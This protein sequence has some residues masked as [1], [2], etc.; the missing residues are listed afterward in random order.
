MK[1]A[2]L[3]RTCLH[4][5]CLCRGCKAMRGDEC[6]RLCRALLRACLPVASVMAS[7]K[8]EGPRP[9]EN[10]EK[11]QSFFPRSL[12]AMDSTTTYCFF[13]SFTQTKENREHKSQSISA[14][15]QASRWQRPLSH[16][17]RN[18]MCL[19]LSLSVDHAAVCV[20]DR[21]KNPR[22]HLREVHVKSRT[23]TSRRFRGARV[24]HASMSSFYYRLRIL[25]GWH[26][27]ENVK[28]HAS[29][30]H[31]WPAARGSEK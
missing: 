5:V 16:F 29:C 1:P 4:E 22:F 14:P 7:L 13:C 18:W 2:I 9:H 30:E 3:H 20:R 28:R 25:Y 26:F 27:G 8:A 11:L 24:N 15:F 17:K 21:G 31:F 19:F 12:N 23:K 6:V 10:C